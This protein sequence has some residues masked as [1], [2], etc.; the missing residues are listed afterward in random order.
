MDNI[1]INGVIGSIAILN[2]G[3]KIRFLGELGDGLLDVRELETGSLFQVERMEDGAKMICDVDWLETTIACEEIRFITGPAAQPPRALNA[4]EY[5]HKQLL[6]K[7]PKAYARAAVVRHLASS[8][9]NWSDEEVVRATNEA[10][11]A[12]LAELT[13]EEQERCGPKPA[14]ETVREWAAKCADP[15]HPT[16]LEL[17]SMSG[18][19][20]RAGRLSPEIEE[21][22]KTYV[23]QYWSLAGWQQED[24]FA[25]LGKQIKEINVERAANGQPLLKTPS[26]ETMRLRINRSLCRDTF[27]IK[28]GEKA[29]KARFDGTGKGLRAPRILAITLIDDTTLD[30]FAV[31][32]AETGL[33]A[34]RPNICVLLDVHS[35]CVL[36]YHLSFEAPSTDTAT[37]C[38]RNA[39]R[40][41]MIKREWL[42]RYP[43]LRGIYGK[44]NEILSDNG[45]GYTSKDWQMMLGELGITL[46]LAAVGEPRH[47]AMIERFFRTLNTFLVGKLPGATRDLKTT[48]EFDLYPSAQAECTIGEL[49]LLIDE[50]LYVYHT[51]IHSGIGMQPLAAWER[52]RAT[53][54]RAIIGDPRVLNVLCGVTDRKA[55]RLYKGT[56]RRL[57]LTYCD[58]VISAELNNDLVAAEPHRDRVASGG[59]VATVKVKTNPSDLGA[60]HV[61]NKV[62]KTWVSL[63]CT[64]PEYACGL[65][66]WQHDKIR[67]WA[68]A[69]NLAFNTPEERTKARA[70][71]ADSIRAVAPK[72]AQRERR[73]MARL[74]GETVIPAVGTATVTYADPRHDGP[75]ADVAHDTAEDRTDADVVPTRPGAAKAPA[76]RTGEVTVARE[77]QVKA[78]FADGATSGGAD[79]LELDEIDNWG[80]EAVDDLLQEFS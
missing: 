38:L 42:D 37:Q 62:K 11:P 17:F 52:S 66:A 55:R 32:D 47:K 73:A 26:K 16:S 75:D 6:E 39:S 15:E 12:A 61:W 53:S 44:P 56:I 49:R 70:D 54:G 59:A 64:D 65:S 69:R 18:R 24:A 29:A 28:F 35:R 27:A 21:L 25:A 7:D 77:A 60:I 8:G 34:G 36:G 40:P 71:L 67:R 58:R 9:F 80:D 79:D 22:L 72:L 23:D 33:P 48:R 74:A 50:F 2:G 20:P 57:G 46:R 51:S 45:S 3:K 30:A 10:W 31:F 19:V 78:L 14:V 13:P 1:G 43:A 63:P 76:R 41:K 5:D 4:P 68:A